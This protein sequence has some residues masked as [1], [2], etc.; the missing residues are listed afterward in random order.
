MNDSVFALSVP[1]D[2]AYL[3]AVRAFF[4]ACLRAEAGDATDGLVLALDE[5]CANV[6]RHRDKALGCATLDVRA[7]LSPA[8]LLR[9][10][11][12]SFCARAD[13]AKIKPRDLADVRPGGLG[14]HFIEK[15][16]DRVLYEPEPGRPERFALVMEKALAPSGGSRAPSPGGG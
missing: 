10:R 11:L 3:A 1:A 8:G 16:M 13:V 5:A 6:I 4:D 2:A 7:E 9:I 14:T 12:G 15:I